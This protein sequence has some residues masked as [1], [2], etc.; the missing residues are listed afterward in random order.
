M[1]E[2]FKVPSDLIPSDPRF[3]VGPSL[4]PIEAVENL[5]KSGSKLLGTSH[6][7]DP[8]KNL[9][10]E[11]QDGLRTYFK[12]P[13]DYEIV[14]GN[15]GAT[16][17]WDM[18]GLGLVEKSSLHYICG[19]FSDKWYRSHKQI[20]WIKAKEV[21]VEFG[22]GINPKEEP[23]YDFIC[24]TLNETSTGVQLSNI[25]KL[26]DPNTLMAVDA[27]SGAGQIPADFTNIDIYYFSPQKV[28]ASDGGFYV[29]IMS[30]KAIARAKKIQEDK[31]RYIPEVM[32][33]SN[34]IE[35]SRGHQ[36][37]NTPAIATIF[38]LNEQIKLMNK[39]G[40][41]KVTELAKKKAELMYGWAEKKPY[42]SPFVKNPEF[43]SQAV[44]CIDVDEKYKVDDLIKV[45]R[46][47]GVAVDIDGYRKL[48]RNQFRIA[49]F[50]NVSY[51]NLEKL[52]KIISLAIESEK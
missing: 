7:K 43:R 47:Q 22:E 27:T 18:M 26:K 5:A 25:P 33:W 24:C 35:N 39:L 31:T 52:T 49:L 16:F 51:E 36:T 9:V 3:G 30:P 1:F 46:A 6:R 28:F 37:Y 12:L 50:H 42:L 23:G 4:I 44:V 20:P 13:A 45:L 19:E 41:A 2:N 48:G 17:L 15:G 38:L 29:A 34:A 40:E 32:K 8:I 11:V 10:K 21:K 14:L